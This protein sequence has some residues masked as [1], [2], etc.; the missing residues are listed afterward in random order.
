MSIDHA[1]GV[2]APKA[3]PVFLHF[4]AGMTVIVDDGSDWR[5]ADVIWVDRWWRQK[6]QGPHAVSGGRH[7]HRRHQLGQR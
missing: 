6:P 7:G 1:S 2:A 3:D 4:R 5:M